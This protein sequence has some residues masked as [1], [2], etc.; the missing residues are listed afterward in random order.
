[1]FE[2][3]RIGGW[4]LL[5]RADNHPYTIPDLEDALLISNL[6]GAMIRNLSSIE[7]ISAL[8]TKLQEQ[9]D[10]LARVQHALLPASVPN[11]PNVRFA[12]SYH[13]STSAGGDSYDFFDL[14]DG[15]LGLLIA[16]VSGHGPAAATV[17]AML[18]AILRARPDL[19]ANPSGALTFANAQLAASSI[20][21]GHVTAV[22]AVLDT[23][24]ATD[25]CSERSVSSRL[26]LARAGH[27]LPRLRTDDGRVSEIPGEGA[28][29]MGIVAD[30]YHPPETSINLHPGQ[31]IVLYTDGITEAENTKSEQFGVTGLDRAIAHSSGEPQAVITSVLSALATHTNN[32]PREDDQ[33]LVVFRIEQ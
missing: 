4:S 9:F 31:T 30:H 13:S 14:G 5:F 19:C 12:V 7:E 1:M 25:R 18:H 22:F 11:I 24:R 21:G 32:A 15:K 8:N 3:G 33:T 2:A 29:P 6:M 16:D 10:G 23:N 28:A 20:E 27:P 26:T 17:M